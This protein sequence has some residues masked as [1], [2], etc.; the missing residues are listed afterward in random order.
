LAS[1]QLTGFSILQFFFVFFLQMYLF[2]NYAKFDANQILIYGVFLY[3]SIYAYTEL[4]DRNANAFWMEL[5][6]N[7]AGLGLFIYNGGWFGLQ[8]VSPI[9]SNLVAGYF[10]FS[11]LMVAYFVFKEFEQ[12]KSLVALSN[13][14]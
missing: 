7:I 10:I 13:N 14:Y 9:A 1:S 11:S 12:E 8:N 4:M 6:K 2:A 3:M 5:L